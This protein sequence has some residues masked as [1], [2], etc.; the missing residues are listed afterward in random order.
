MWRQQYLFS[1]FI[2]QLMNILSLFD[3]ISCAKVALHKCKLHINQYF[4]SEIDKY[5]IIISNNNHKDIIRLGDIRQ[6]DTKTLPK[7]DILIGGS[8]CQDLSISKQNRK[9]L[10]GSRSVLFYEY[11]RILNE[12]NPRYFILENVASMSKVDKEIISQ[13]LKVQ[14]ILLDASLV[15]AQRRKRLFWTNIKNIQLPH[16]RNISLQSILEDG[17]ALYNK[18]YCIDANYHKGG[19]V[20][21]I[22]YKLKNNLPRSQIENRIMV[23]N[24]GG[25]YRKLT[26]IE[27]ERLQG[28]PDNYTY[29]VSNTQRYKCL[30]NAFN[31]DIVTHILSYL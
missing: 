21:K 12:I 26:P 5:A 25:S 10:Q 4:S 7:I 3:G 13:E 18:S 27:C 24:N 28:L 31:V 30:G 1:F 15:S 23:K 14:P 2:K 8:P 17:T 9:G 11:C 22:E 29:G 19:P 20:S 16:D 6:I